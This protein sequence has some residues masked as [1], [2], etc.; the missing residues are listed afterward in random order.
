M[1]AG[2][3][4]DRRQGVLVE[5]VVPEAGMIEGQPSEAQAAAARGT[6]RKR[7]LLVLKVLV[8]LALIAWILA[9]THV[10]EIFQA[11]GTA[12][13]GLLLIAF[14]SHALGFTI[15]AYRWRTLLRARGSDASIRFLIESY[16]VGMFFNNF[17]PS[18]VGGDVYRAYDSWRVGQ[19]RSGAVAV[20]VVDRFLGLL[21][22]M[23][24][25]TVALLSSN[26]LTQTIPALSLWVGAGTVALAG[27]VGVIFMAPAGLSAWVARLQLPLMNKIRGLIEAFLSFRGNQRVLLKALGL[28]V[29]LQANVVVHYYLIA[30]A[31]S[32]PVP[33]SAF[34]LIIPL[35]TVV[36]MLPIAINGIGVREGVYAFFFASFGVAQPEAI[37]FAWIAYG[38]VL[39]Q[40]I[41]GGVLYAFRR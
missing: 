41:L 21:A 22:L 13:V 1:Q 17:L 12:H 33:L 27:L 24:F 31:L 7:L 14:S 4:S 25:A 28:S 18:T 37:A 26:A 32:L 35:A 15:S 40:G 29:L 36:L 16:I 30:R 20:V 2:D 10:A 39:V 23:L 11:M 9:G 3:Q 34:F 6:S 38:M 19:S 8:S 5:P